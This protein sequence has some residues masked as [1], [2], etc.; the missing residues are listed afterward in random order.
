MCRWPCNM[1]EW[2]WWDL[3]NFVLFLC[4]NRNINGLSRRDSVVITRSRIGHTRLTHSYLLS[5]ENRPNCF[6]YCLV[7][8][9]SWWN[10]RSYRWKDQSISLQL[11]WKTF[12]NMSIH[13]LLSTLLK[14]FTFMIAR[15]FSFMFFRYQC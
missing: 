4:T 8:H 14:I 5:K 7:T 1:V 10:V 12:L 13:L 2:F 11:R 6:C 9:I 3:H 15:S